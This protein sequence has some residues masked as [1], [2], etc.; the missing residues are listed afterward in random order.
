MRR[1]FLSVVAFRPVH[2][3]WVST[4]CFICPHIMYRAHWLCCSHLKKRAVQKCVIHQQWYG[5]NC[6]ETLFLRTLG[7]DSPNSGAMLRERLHGS[8]STATVTPYS[9]IHVRTFHERL[10]SCVLLVLHLLPHVDAAPIVE[11]CFLLSISV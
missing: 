10:H 5:C 1:G 8:H 4:T 7:W 6:H 9:L 11:T 3:C 2:I